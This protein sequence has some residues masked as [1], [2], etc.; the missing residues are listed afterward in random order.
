MSSPP[1]II[2][3]ELLDELP[4]EDPRARRS[5]QDLR[6]V[7]AWMGNGR[8]LIRALNGLPINPPSTLA[9]LGAGDGDLMLRLGKRLA[10]RWP[11]VRVWLVD[12]HRL[13]TAQTTEQFARLGWTADAVRADALEWLSHAQA[14]DVIVAN[15]FLHHCE[16]GA[17]RMLFGAVADRTQAFIAC[18]PRRRRFAWTAGL[19]LGLIGCGAVTRHDAVV[20]VRAG[21]SDGELSRLWPQRE[22]WSL[23]EGRAGLFSH[24]FAAWREGG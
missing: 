7:N 11:G 13:L 18:E 19:M 16:A 24:R 9:E 22:S 12:Q 8:I 20:S 6:R 2:Q 4:P 17:L 15:L 21:F 23:R 10:G 1:R 3:P 5:R 14:V